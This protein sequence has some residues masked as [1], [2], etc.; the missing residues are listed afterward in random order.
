M[1][2]DEKYGGICEKWCDAGRGNTGLCCYF[3]KES[4]KDVRCLRINSRYI[5]DMIAA[6]EAAKISE[7]PW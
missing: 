1:E 2:N 6:V 3:F 5:N 4:H 7:S